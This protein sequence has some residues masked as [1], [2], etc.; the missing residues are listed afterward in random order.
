MNLSVLIKTLQNILD[1]CGET[2]DIKIE[3]KEIAWVDF[4]K[5]NYTEHTWVKIFTK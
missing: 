3:G 2:S 5:N 1:E 4:E